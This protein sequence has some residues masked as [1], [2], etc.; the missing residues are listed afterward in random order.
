MATYCY[1]T[2]DGEVVERF[3]PMKEEIPKLIELPD[4]RLAK[5]SFSA[6]GGAGKRSGGTGWPLECEA[7]GVHP[8]QR[9][10]LADFLNK[11]G[12]PTEVSA[13]GNPL[14]RNPHHRRNVLKARGLHDRNSYI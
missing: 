6:E 7:S 13:N 1:K 14:Y 12:V 4:G 2:E 9:K 3:F 10:E 8:S 5:R 11:R